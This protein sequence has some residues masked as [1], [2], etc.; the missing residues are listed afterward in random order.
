MKRR[1][2]ITVFL[3]LFVVFVAACAPS[4]TATPSQSSTRSAASNK[5][6]GIPVF[7]GAA[8]RSDNNIVGA[9]SYTVSNTGIFDVVN[10]YKEQMKATGWE[11]LGV[12]NTSVKG[13]GQ[14]YS[15]W[16]SKGGD[17]LV[18]EIFTRKGNIVVTLHFE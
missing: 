17:L 4:N 18:V 11:L 2:W 13:V 15:L 16:F 9:R 8:E 1:K 3:L 6:E 12:G 14:A 7:P 5:W 10:F